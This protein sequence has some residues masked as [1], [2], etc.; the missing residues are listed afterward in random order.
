[1][2]PGMQIFSIFSSAI[3]Q[4]ESITSQW[5]LHPICILQVFQY[6]N[7][8][9]TIKWTEFCILKWEDQQKHL[10]CPQ[11]GI[12]L[13]RISF[14]WT[15]RTKYFSRC[16]YCTKYWPKSL[17]PAVTCCGALFTFTLCLK[18]MFMQIYVRGIY[19]GLFWLVPPKSVWGWPNPYQKS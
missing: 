3:F 15:F 11:N 5:I 12:I 6:N 2:L 14:K 4:R 16:A 17:L 18:K 8:H 9:H 10:Y 1:M 19:R 13:I 7:L